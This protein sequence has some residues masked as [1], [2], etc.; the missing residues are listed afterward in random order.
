MA[1][2]TSAQYYG[3]GGVLNNLTD[4]QNRYHLVGTFS[5][6]QRPSDITLTASV[7]SIDGSMTTINAQTVTTIDGNFYYTRGQEAVEES[8]DE[9]ILDDAGSIDAS[10]SGSFP[11]RTAVTVPTPTVDDPDDDE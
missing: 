9:S 5:G 3:G 1:T 8:D 7:G 6:N 10:V 11:F 4:G 2:V